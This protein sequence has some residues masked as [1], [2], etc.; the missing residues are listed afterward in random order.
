MF[1]KSLQDL[2]KGI[3]A[4]KR[5]PAARES[6]ATIECK[7]EL[8][9]WT[10]SSRPRRSG[11]LTYLQMLGYDVSWAS[12]AIAETMSQPAVCSKADR[13]LGGVPVFL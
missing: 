6:T 3:R 1:E 13:I 5:D 11:K 2:V 12:F 7:K 10:P 4:H 9:M 8:K